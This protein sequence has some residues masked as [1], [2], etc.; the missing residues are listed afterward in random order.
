[1]MNALRL[2]KGF[3]VGLFTQRTGLDIKAILPAIEKE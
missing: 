2:K 1:M 3:N